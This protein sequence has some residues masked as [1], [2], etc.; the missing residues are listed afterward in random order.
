[1][2]SLIVTHGLTVRNRS[3]RSRVGEVVDGRTCRG[4][5]ACC[6]LQVANFY[7]ALKNLTSWCVA[8]YGNDR[9][10]AQS[11]KNL[12]DVHAIARSSGDY[13][14][15]FTLL[16][17]LVTRASQLTAEHDRRHGDSIPSDR[18]TPS[19]D[20]YQKIKIDVA[21]LKLALLSHPINIVMAAFLVG[22]QCL[23][24]YDK[25]SLGVDPVT[26]MP[27]NES[28]TAESFLLRFPYEYLAVVYKVSYELYVNKRFEMPAATWFQD[29]TIM[30]PFLER[31]RADIDEAR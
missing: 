10:A 2:I 19:R 25:V 12:Y 1:M 7:S 11:W 22:D 5:F 27:V 16:D 13:P 17:G 18:I 15:L 30:E 3:C 29:P 24:D 28:R 4:P 9:Y 23:L 6:I 20:I 8:K 21:V 14:D 31:A 26:K